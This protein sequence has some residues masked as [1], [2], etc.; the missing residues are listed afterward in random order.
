MDMASELVEAAGGGLA[1]PRAQHYFAHLHRAR[2][3][4][5]IGAHERESAC[6]RCHRWGGLCD[7]WVSTS[8]GL[9]GSQTWS[10]SLTF[11][12]V[13]GTVLASEAPLGAPGSLFT[14][15]AYRRE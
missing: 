2:P 9:I 15:Q 13:Y 8:I 14:S 3:R 12:N 5:R 1:Q 6:N 10:G 7:L 4:G 11:G